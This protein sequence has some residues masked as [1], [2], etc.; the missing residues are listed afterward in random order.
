VKCSRLEP[1]PPSGSS[2]IAQAEAKLAGRQQQIDAHRELASSLA[3]DA[4]AAG[5]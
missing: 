1:R 5:S 4:V 3:I 2:A